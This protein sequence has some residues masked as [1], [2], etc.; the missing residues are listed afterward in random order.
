M[1]KEM[2]AQCSYHGSICYLLDDI[3][4]QRTDA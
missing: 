3:P 4:F 1:S 2:E